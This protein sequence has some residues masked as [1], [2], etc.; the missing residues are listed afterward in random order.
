[1]NPEIFE[2]IHENSVEQHEKILKDRLLDI[3][4]EYAIRLF[5]KKIPSP[6][7][8]I[9][10]EI[11]TFEQIINEFTDLYEKIKEAYNQRTGEQLDSDVNYQE[12][13]RVLDEVIINLH[14]EYVKDPVCWKQKID[15]LILL[16]INKLPEGGESFAKDKQSKAGI[17]E[18]N[19]IKGLSDLGEFGIGPEDE[20]IKIHLD[21]FFKQEEL[22]GGSN[23]FFRNYFQ[24]L[25]HFFS[26]NHPNAKAIVAES[27][28]LGSP[29]AKRIGFHTYPSLNENTFHGDTFWGQFL[30]Q[31]GQIKEKKIREFLD[32]GKPP[33]VVKSGY[34]LIGEFLKR[35]SLEK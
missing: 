22:A 21:P 31:Q 11:M 6:S 28:L 34:I 32:T 1:M 2:K 17:L 5:E 35:Y 33:F 19:V 8:A 26:K 12:F 18:Y 14:N 30:D 13:E 15:E 10:I 27:W 3:Q 29:I 9:N 20:C 4:L 25:A 7:K 24:I 23:I 16:S